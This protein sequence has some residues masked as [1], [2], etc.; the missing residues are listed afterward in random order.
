M[1]WKTILALLLVPLMLVGVGRWAQQQMEE[2]WMSFVEY[3]T[4][5]AFDLPGGRATEPLTDRVVLVLI[6]G[7]RVDR[8]QEMPTLRRLMEEGAYRIAVTGEPSLSYPSWT[9]VA[10]GTYQEISGVITNWYEGQV[11]VDNVFAAAQRAGLRTVLVGSPGWEMLFGPW[12]DEKHVYDKEGSEDPDLDVSRKVVELARV[13]KLGDLNLVYF[14]ATDDVAHAFGGASEEYARA[15]ARIDELLSQV[16]D[17]LDP[18][19]T[20]LVVTSDHGHIDTGG[21]G[22]WEPVVK[23]VPLILW[24][25]GVKAGS[26]GGK[27]GQA[28]IA[29]TIAALLGTPH[30]THSTGM[31]L[32]EM[33]D[34]SEDQRAS[35]L[36]A[37]ADVQAAFTREYV[38]F[39]RGEEPQLEVSEEDPARLLDEAASL[40]ESA[41]AA[42][43]AT[44]RWARFPSAVAVLLVILALAYLALRHPGRVRT[45]A[46]IATYFVLYN[47]LFFGRGYRYSL[48]VFN[49]EAYIM[50]FFNSRLMDAAACLVLAAAVTALLVAWRRRHT[51]REL[52]WT[53]E[54]MS[55]GV[56]ALLALQALWMYY[57]WGFA[58]EWYLPDLRPAFKFYLDLLQ[59]VATGFAAVIAPLVGLLVGKIIATL[60]PPPGRAV[61]G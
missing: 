59:M 14:G 30:P 36:A 3:R 48:S 17:A 37:V 33:L 27:V 23:E 39:H 56:F 12:F 19:T 32:V 9:V 53:V 8:A 34:L 40:R 45:L 6:D 10:T 44:G 20:T 31:V 21:H 22:G 7:L 61:R 41:R 55:L 51:V 43:L 24:G 15:A 11:K 57:T 50:D 2:S 52:V 25:R 42:H 4:P 18:S 28:D 49:E 58:Y 29:P 26:Y 16:V 13:G 47:L 1:N 35:R 5:Y 54:A 46:G 60:V 38:A